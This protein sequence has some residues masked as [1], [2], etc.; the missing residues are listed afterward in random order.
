MAQGIVLVVSSERQRIGVTSPAVGARVWFKSTGEVVLTDKTGRFY[1]QK[2][3][4]VKS[5]IIISLQGYRTLESNFNGKEQTYYLYD[6]SSTVFIEGERKGTN[7]N[8]KGLHINEQLNENEFKKAACCTLSESFETTNTVEVN[9]A[10]GISGIRQIEMLGLAGKY[11][12]STRD[13]LPLMRGLSVLTGMNQVPG[14]MVSGVHI[15]KG[16]GSVSSGFEGLTGGINYSMKADPRDPKLFLNGYINNQLRGEGNL[17]FKAKLNP[18]TWN[19]SYLHYGGQWRTMDQGGDGMTDMPLTNRVVL[20]NQINHW[21]KKS[22][23]VAGVNQVFDQRRGGDLNNFRKGFVQPVMRFAFDMREE[24]TDA[25]FKLGVFLNESGSK[26]IGQIVSVNKHQTHANLHNLNNRKYHGNQNTLFYSATYASPE[27]KLWSTR[28]GVQF[29]LDDVHEHYSDS[30]NMV[31]QPSRLESNAGFFGEVIRKTKKTSWLLGLRADYNNL[32]GW[33]VTPRFHGRIA[34]GEKS[35][36]HLQAGRGIRTAW[37]YSEFLPLLISNRTLIIQTD[38]NGKAYGLNR[39]DALNTGISL[40][41]NFTAFGYPATL[42]TDFF[43]TK[44]FNQVVADRDED[45]ETLIIRSVRGNDSRI[46]QT[47]LNLMPHRRVEIKL[48]YRYVKT[49]QLLGGE[50]RI[51]PLQSL[52]RALAVISVK[53]RKQWF[54]DA[55]FQY[56]SS[57][58]MPGIRPP[59]PWTEL[60]EYSPAYVI[61]NLMVRKNVGKQWEFYTGA[62]NLLNVLQRN[63]VMGAENPYVKWFDAAYAWGPVNGRNLVAGF[64]MKIK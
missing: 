62:E 63:P 13:N 11:V 37:I 57:K 25:W 64:R 29:T 45:Y 43:Y 14:P 8:G 5:E 15:S 21:G 52:H 35:S 47:D 27:D 1:P 24:K 28:T 9:N 33:A 10:D 7:I 40:V 22:E 12:L 39:E 53:N 38:P 59:S 36:L 6:S 50:R 26:S 19:F 49:L 42:S 20:G 3:T 30:G 44:F 34:L 16:T 32:Y 46:W 61:I 60:P 4:V 23:F 41:K 2:S 55:I 31:Y 58:R 54:A 48:S 51:Q 18:R 17:I 56:N